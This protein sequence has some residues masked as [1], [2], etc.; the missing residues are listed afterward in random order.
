MSVNEEETEEGEMEVEEE[1]EEEEDGGG[2]GRL[3]GAEEWLESSRGKEVEAE[4]GEMR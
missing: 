1:R 3:R 4:R 2:R